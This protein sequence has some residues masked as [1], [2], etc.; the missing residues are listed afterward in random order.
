MKS[1]ING[2]GIVLHTGLGRAPMDKKIAKSIVDRVS[3]YTNLEFDLISG[4]RGD[5]QDHIKGLLSSLTGAESGMAVNNNAAAVLL[6]LN[7][8]SEG[9]EV[10]V[11][12]GQQVEIGGSFRIPDVIEKSGCLIKEVGST[13]RSHFKDY[14]EAINK[15]TGL[16]LWVH[17]SNY[18]VKG[19]TKEV[20][21]SELVQL[22]KKKRIPVM[23][24]LGCG[25]IFDLS[26]KGIPKSIMIQDLS[27]IH[28]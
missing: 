20:P 21:L 27:L 24:D 4:K 25:E 1:I 10:I 7:E 16:I 23:A 13:N 8:L 28:I 5:R 11:S 14:E 19:F 22:G 15:N 17:T 3:G 6:A 12:R 2:T 26:S 18:L 9:N